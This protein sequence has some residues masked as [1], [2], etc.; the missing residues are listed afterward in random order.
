VH[1]AAFVDLT[2]DFAPFE[3]RAAGPFEIT[4]ERQRDASVQTPEFADNAEQMSLAGDRTHAAR[5]LT[6]R[7]LCLAP[8]PAKLPPAREPDDKT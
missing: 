3:R 6:T 5:S 1:I 2:K 4:F 7:P 8:H